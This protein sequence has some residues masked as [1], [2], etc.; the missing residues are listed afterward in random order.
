MPGSK[1]GFALSSLVAIAATLSACASGPSATQASAALGAA[2]EAIDHARNDNG[3]NAA[4]RILVEAQ[5]KLGQGQAAAKN[6]DNASAI[7]LATEAK[8][9][10]DL[11]DATAQAAKAR[12]SA[13][14]VG[15]GGSTP[16]P[17]PN[18]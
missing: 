3:L 11:A 4:P 8:A 17:L 10:A 7:R 18:R 12:E 9:D 14:A 13:L 2:G 6:G 15:S 5:Q 16:N 1:S